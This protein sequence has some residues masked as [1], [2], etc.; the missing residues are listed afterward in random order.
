[1]LGSLCHFPSHPSTSLLTRLP[2]LCTSGKSLH[3]LKGHWKTQSVDTLQTVTPRGLPR[4]GRGCR[5]A[6]DPL[7]QSLP[8]LFPS[9]GYAE[10]KVKYKWGFTCDYN[11]LSKLTC[12]TIK[13]I[14]TD[15]LIQY[16]KSLVSHLNSLNK[17]LGLALLCPQTKHRQQLSSTKSLI[18]MP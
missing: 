18:Q 13:M 11:I 5:F 3:A 15:V 7:W 12:T 1:M 10:T 8:D 17:A 4:G 9:T 6:W 16:F 14:S 2:G